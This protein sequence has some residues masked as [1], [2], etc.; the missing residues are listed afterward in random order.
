MVRIEKYFIIVTVAQDSSPQLFFMKHISPGPWLR[1]YCKFTY[2]SKFVEI[3]EFEHFFALLLTTPIIFLPDRQHR[4]S[5]LCAVVHNAGK[6]STLW[7]TKQKNTHELKLEHFSMLLPTIRKNYWQCRPKRGTFFHIVDNN[8]EKYLAL[9][10]TT[11]N[12]YYKV[13]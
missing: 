12:N 9:W 5:F 3:F 13:D 7:T 4:W 11:Q 2:W 1:P 6:W 8:A 10:A